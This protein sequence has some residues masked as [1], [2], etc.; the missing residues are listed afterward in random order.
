MNVQRV[1]VIRFSAMGDVAMTLPVLQQALRENPT[2]DI[3]L[4]TQPAFAPLFEHNERLLV[5]PVA[6]SQYKGLLGLWRL[7]REL[8]STYT[9]HQVADLHDVLR[10]RIIRF[11]FRLSGK[12][13]FSI[14]KDRGAKKKI[15]TTKKTVPLIHT[16]DRYRQVFQSA[17]FT[18][19][20]QP[21]PLP[22]VL[23]SSA[24]QAFIDHYLH[25]FTPP[26]VAFAPFAKHATKTLPID[27]SSQLIAALSTSHTVFLLGGKEDQ[28]KLEILTKQHTRTFLVSNLS[29][30]QQV[31]L[32][33]RMETVITMDSANMHLAAIQQV[34]VVSVWGSTHPCFGFNGIQT[35][36]NGIVQ[37]TLSLPCRPC[38]V[39]GN[40]PC[41][42]KQE[43][44]QCM[45]SIT[46][47]QIVQAFED[48]RRKQH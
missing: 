44:M 45:S 38:S 22:A 6:L 24:D 46:T 32:M 35:D 9:I 47:G 36:P 5:H 10:S 30:I 28:D 33:Q 2:L 21:F 40:K 16:T 18:L 23:V 25:P 12:P 3:V 41:T 34:P 31:G 43:P 15:L 20:A 26:F 11:L 19:S 29:F 39:F 17:G 14:K 27:Q 37:T 42:N 48:V 7:V 13:V 4:L 8:K 1:L